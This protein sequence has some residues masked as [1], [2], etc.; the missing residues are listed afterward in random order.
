MVREF[1]SGRARLRLPQ[2][3]EGGPPHGR[4][5]ELA[6]SRDGSRLAYV[7]QERR[8]RTLRIA[9]VR[10]GRVLRRVDADGVYRFG[11]DAFSSAGDRLAYPGGANLRLTLLD[12]ATGKVQRSGQTGVLTVAWAPAGER[13]AMSTDDGVFASDEH[14]HFGPPE[15]AWD[16]VST[17]H[18]SPDGT[19]LGFLTQSFT[20][21]KVELAVMAALPSL[22]PPRLI[23][24][25]R[26]PGLGAFR[27]SPDGTRIVYAG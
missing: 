20:E 16:S 4:S 24:P 14:R 25:A 13:L 1:A 17:L 26:D 3:P 5:L 2:Y 6:W 9:D 12:V 18:W 8:G 15:T 23:V 7:A 22:G 27:W 10:G 11:P 21:V 19:T